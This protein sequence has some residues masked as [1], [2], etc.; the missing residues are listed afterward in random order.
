MKIVFV[1]HGPYFSE[2]YYHLYNAFKS[3]EINVEFITNSNLF[4]RFMKNRSINV[5]NIRN[6][7]EK[8]SKKY[9]E[10]K[11]SKYLSKYGI[12]DFTAFC[13]DEIQ[14][15][16]LNRELLK[17]DVFCHLAFFED[18][19]ENNRPDCICN[20]SEQLLSK[21]CEKVANKLGIIFLHP[22]GSVFPNTLYWDTS[23][24]VN[25]WVRKDYL[26][27]NLN[28]EEGK[29]VL[30][31]VEKTKKE[32][33]VIGGTINSVSLIRVVRRFINYTYNYILV[34]RCKNYDYTPSQLI[35][36]YIY[37]SL[38]QRFAKKYYSAPNF[39]EQYIFFPLHV[40]DDAQIT[41]RAIP[42]YRQDKVVELCSKAIPDDYTLYVKEHPHGKG[43]IPLD[44]LKKIAY[45]SNVKLVP[46]DINA[47]DLIEH[48]DA[49]I[50]IN[51]DVG[52]EALL[53]YKP[54]IV[55]AKPFY[56][57]LGLTFDLDFQNL[58]VKLTEDAG[59]LRKLSKKIREALTQG[60]VNKDKVHV[61]VNAVMKS[62]YFGCSFYDEEYDAENIKRITDSILDKYSEIK[63]R[64]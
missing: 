60:K 40:P 7:F 14:R 1:A 59:Y 61:L 35:K 64:E 62:V 44:W 38:R 26:N 16:K 18:Y 34:E 2:L 63:G 57:G 4:E 20:A 29:K 47:H 46:P 51:S 49:I 19:F 10:E 53:H 56:S 15:Y 31:Y 42:F 6:Y 24:M 30:E 36:T 28:E 39:S 9:S 25:E 41:F 11:L 48:S 50:T 17:V 45:L 55:L 32:K 22:G 21:T 3:H 33:P 8:Y 23:L 5:V 58:N 37:S 54:V 43:M 13:F 27:K 52:W 12:P